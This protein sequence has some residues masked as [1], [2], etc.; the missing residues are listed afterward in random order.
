[1]ELAEY[2][3]KAVRTAKDLPREKALLHVICL[4]ADEVGELGS[5]IKKAEVYGQ[6]WNMD[7]VVEELGDILYGVAYAAH[8]FGVSLETVGR[9]NNEKLA[10]RFPDGYS[11]FHAAARL[12]K[13]VA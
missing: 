11:D 1:M 3:A 8:V 2:Q 6:P 9:L 10:I 4:L 7:N 5:A 13:E 12:D